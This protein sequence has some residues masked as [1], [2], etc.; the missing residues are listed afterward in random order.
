MKNEKSKSWP[1]EDPRRNTSVFTSCPKHA[2]K[3]RWSVPH[4][5][6]CIQPCSQLPGLEVKTYK[7]K[8]EKK[9]EYKVRRAGTHGNPCIK[10]VEVEESGI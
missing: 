10:R 3:Q 2:G 4:S 6:C 5:P 7:Q 8:K 1:P 9:K